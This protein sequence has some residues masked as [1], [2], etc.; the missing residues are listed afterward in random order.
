[1]QP[2]TWLI[3]DRNIYLCIDCCWIDN[4][5]K[6]APFIA[7]NKRVARLAL[8]ACIIYS[9]CTVNVSLF[10]RIRFIL[11]F[12]SSDSSRPVTFSPLWKVACWSHIFNSFFAMRIGAEQRCCI[13]E[14][15]FESNGSSGI[16][17]GKVSKFNSTLGRINH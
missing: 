14:P 3:F 6:I 13:L 10:T 7:R 9:L 5:V 12:S 15:T 8:I 17:W 11:F 1:M 2:V 16:L 4:Y